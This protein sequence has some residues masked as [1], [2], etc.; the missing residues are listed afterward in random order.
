MFTCGFPTGFISRLRALSALPPQPVNVFV[1]LAGVALLVVIIAFVT[2][3]FLKK[4]RKLVLA[5]TLAMLVVIA[6]AGSVW[7]LRAQIYYSFDTVH[8]YPS[9]GDNYFTINCQNTGYVA[10]SFSLKVHF[11]NA[12]VSSKTNQTYEALDD[13]FVRFDYVLEPGQRQSTQVYFVIQDNVTDFTISLA[14][15]QNYDFL[16]TSDS[17][18]NT[19]LAFVKAP[20]GDTFTSQG[21][22]VPP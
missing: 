11:D 6:V 12:Q 17:N 8:D 13:S 15:E 1:V 3:Y 14:Q 7:F 5:I 10:G 22:P 19:Y 9:V 2:R 20:S 16:T 4:R 21:A 18:G